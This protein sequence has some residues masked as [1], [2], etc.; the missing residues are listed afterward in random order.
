MQP[1]TWDC[2]RSVTNWASL[3]SKPLTSPSVLQVHPSPHQLSLAASDPLPRKDGGKREKLRGSRAP[4]PHASSSASWEV[5]A[6]SPVALNLKSQRQKELPKLH[7][8]SQLLTSRSSKPR[9][10]QPLL[11]PEAL[12]PTERPKDRATRPESS[13]GRGRG[14]VKTILT[15]HLTRSLASQPQLQI[16]HRGSGVQQVCSP[17]R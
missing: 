2:D 15:E 9:K 17:G 5:T 14:G 13:S 8:S 6:D 1:G 16:Q 12:N 10:E 7:R 4:H 3:L 11:L